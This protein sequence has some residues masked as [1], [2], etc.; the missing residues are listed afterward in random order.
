MYLQCL[1]DQSQF[2]LRISFETLCNGQLMLGWTE[3]ASSSGGYLEGALEASERVLQ[4][5]LQH[6]AAS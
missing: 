5:L 4:V 2:G 6:E 1:H 3:T